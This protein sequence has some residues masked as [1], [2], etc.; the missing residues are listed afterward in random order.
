M[1]LRVGRRG[2]FLACSGY[3]ECKHTR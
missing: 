3:P 1:L 2:P